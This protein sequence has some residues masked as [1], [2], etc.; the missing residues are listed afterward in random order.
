MQDNHRRRR[1]LN[2]TQL[3]SINN[4]MA[5]INSIIA[6][7]NKILTGNLS[8]ES[9]VI[10]AVSKFSRPAHHSRLQSVKVR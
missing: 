2:R 6:K 10:L 3:N 7:E 9:S 5:D 8:S 1:L 4:S